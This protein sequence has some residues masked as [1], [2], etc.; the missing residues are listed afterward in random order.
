MLNQQ[1]SELFSE[2]VMHQF[3]LMGRG[4]LISL[5]KSALMMEI[6]REFSLSINQRINHITS[7]FVSFQAPGP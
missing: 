2:D 3:S 7:I 6:A 5:R 4:E 1:L